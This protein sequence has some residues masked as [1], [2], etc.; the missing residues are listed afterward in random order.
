V[1]A[2]LDVQHSRLRRQFGALALRVKSALTSRA[3]D[4]LEHLGCIADL[5]VGEPGVC[6]GDL[7]LALL[8]HS[9][10]RRL[11]ICC[12]TYLLVGQ[13]AFHALCELPELR[14]LTLDYGSRR[15]NKWRQ[16]HTPMVRP[17]ACSGL[18]F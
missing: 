16:Q 6:G 13:P 3:L 2:G 5:D 14:E 10:F 15:N 9:G 1:R 8:V 7:L 12:M 4:Q 17:S 11:Q 18:G